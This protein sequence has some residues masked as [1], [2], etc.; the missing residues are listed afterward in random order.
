[1]TL[2]VRETAFLERFTRGR[3]PGTISAR[4]AHERPEPLMMFLPVEKPTIALMVGLRCPGL[5]S[6][7]QTEQLRSLA[8]EAH[9]PLRANRKDR[10]P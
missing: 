6:G 9:A 3:M 7:G 2:Y 8:L 5:T 4:S 10:R 1:M